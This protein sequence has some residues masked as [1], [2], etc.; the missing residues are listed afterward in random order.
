MIT[1]TSFPPRDVRTDLTENRLEKPL[2]RG[3]RETLENCERVIQDGL[4]TFIEVGGALSVIRDQ[5][6]YRSSHK[7]FEDYC[8]E[9]WDMTGRRARQ[10]CAAA[11]VVRNLLAERSGEATAGN[12]TQETNGTDTA[13]P[14][15]FPNAPQIVT[16]RTIMPSMHAS[17]PEPELPKPTSERQVRPLTQLPRE[18]Q[19]P[20]YRDAV[21]AAGGKAPTVEQVEKAV[22]R[23]KSVEIVVPMARLDQGGDIYEAY[24]GVQLTGAEPCMIS[25]PFTHD[26]DLFCTSS[27]MVEGMSDSRFRKRSAKAHRLIPAADYD[28]PREVPFS[29]QGMLVLWKGKRY[30]LG[31]AI[32]FKGSL[33]AN[34]Q[35]Q[36][37]DSR[38]EKILQEAERTVIQ[39]RRLQDLID[40]TDTPMV[41]FCESAVQSIEALEVKF[42]RKRNDALARVNGWEAVKPQ[43]AAKKPKVSMAARALMQA[44]AKARWAAA[45]A[46]G[47][48][49]NGTNGTHS[50]EESGPFVILRKRQGKKWYLTTGG[51]WTWD[52]NFAAEFKNRGAAVVR[53]RNRHGE[54]VKG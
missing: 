25:T 11:G 22:T 26:E 34:S 19:R 33:A 40:K 14:D 9:K 6:L 15:L 47:N 7:T 8:R 49:T 48:G 28:G 10:L 4:D 38:V 45:K 37:P 46:G 21:Q 20:A 17:E 23:R 52:R 51:G 13:E 39:I 29:S 3:E 16:K 1:N 54:I 36:K 43:K 53:L 41:R 12:G 18:E 35:E 5:R 30:R 50:A 2:D 27:V 42:K 32:S 44:R 31:E 24:S